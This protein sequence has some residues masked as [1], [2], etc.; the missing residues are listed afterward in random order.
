[1]MYL[2]YSYAHFGSVSF[3]FPVIGAS[4]LISLNLVFAGTPP[5]DLLLN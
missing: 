4:K 2:A 3:V 5:L 1:M